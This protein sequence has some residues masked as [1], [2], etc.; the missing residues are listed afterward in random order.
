MPVKVK[1]L[2]LLAVAL[3]APLALSAQDDRVSLP[4]KALAPSEVFYAIQQQTSYYVIVNQD[5]MDR[6]LS[7]T[8]VGQSVGVF[9][10]L[11][12]LFRGTPYTYRV[13]G[14]FIHV[15]VERAVR[16]A[17]P[18][19]KGSVSG[20]V[21]EQ[22]T[23][24]PLQ[25]VAVRIAGT[26]FRAVT[27]R[28]GLFAVAGIPGGVY[29]VE[30]RLPEDG[31][32]IYRDVAVAAG[33]DSRMRILAD[34]GFRLTMADPI[35][36]GAPMCPAASGVK[37]AGDEWVVMPQAAASVLPVNPVVNRIPRAA[38]KTN[39]LYL[40]AATPNL[41]VEVL[42]APKWTMELSAGLNVWNFDDQGRGFRH[43]SVRPEARYWFG[44]SFKGHF[45]GISASYLKFQSVDMPLGK[46]R[47][48]RY[49]GWAAGGGLSYG[50]HLPL[51]KKWSMEFTVGLGVAYT[52]YEEYS[53]GMCGVGRGVDSK[54]YWVPTKLGV[55]LMFMIR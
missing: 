14:R 50:Y 52:E 18:Q 21:I 44:Q 10:I 39:L 12:E 33:T 42:L 53:C 16:T 36:A 1:I 17:R 30:F 7:V 6:S 3:A 26:P 51:A 4:E 34:T 43:V 28:D 47:D 55:S 9:E 8:P 54:L 38:I 20:E 32:V 5:K 15:P 11:D 49:D 19:P 25:G 46:L 40:V 29:T 2:V 22:Y 48:N 13:D 35:A 24:E 23:K 41:A 27:D 37:M 45:M 31:G